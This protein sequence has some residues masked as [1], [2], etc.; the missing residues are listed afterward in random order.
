MDNRLS[1]S[2]NIAMVAYRFFLYNIWIICPF[3]TP[4]LTQ[5]LVPVLVLAWTT[6]ILFWLPSNFSSSSR[7][8]Q[9][10]VWASTSPDT[11]TSPP[12]HF[13]PL[14]SCYVLSQIQNIGSIFPGK[15][16]GQPQLTS[17]RSSDPTRQPAQHAWRLPL[18]EIPAHECCLFRR[19]GGRIT[20]PYRSEL[21]KLWPSASLHLSPP[22]PTSL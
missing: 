19:H 21:Q 20:S 1:H 16:R 11:P 9:Q 22:L 6:V 3:L 5:L 13:P 8:Q 10:L 4:Y 14:D 15:L 18:S 7:M 17:K 12:A 2:E